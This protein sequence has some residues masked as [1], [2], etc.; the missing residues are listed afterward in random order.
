M[1]YHHCFSSSVWT[2]SGP[3]MVLRN[4]FVSFSSV[5]AHLMRWY[6]HCFTFDYAT[7]RYKMTLNGEVLTEGTHTAD[8]GRLKGRKCAL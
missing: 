3:I 6:H 7:G 2:A 1:L 4:Q 5:S 8:L